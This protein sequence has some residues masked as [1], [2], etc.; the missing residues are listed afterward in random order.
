MKKFPKSSRE[1]TEATEKL[2]IKD[3]F[4]GQI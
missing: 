1:I 4:V 3:P 2:A